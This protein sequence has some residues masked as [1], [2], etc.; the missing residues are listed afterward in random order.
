VAAS[1]SFRHSLRNRAVAEVLQDNGFATLQLDLLTTDE[2]RVDRHTSE[3]R[4][5][6]PLLADRAV[7]AVEQIDGQV[8]VRGVS[9][10]LFGVI[11]VRQ[12]H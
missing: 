4:F 3:L 7:T 10:G 8:V 2:E 1:G 12:R 5:D 9:V 6:I 11:T